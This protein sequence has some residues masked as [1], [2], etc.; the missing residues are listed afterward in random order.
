MPL[1]HFGMEQILRTKMENML[2][3][4]GL[5]IFGYGVILTGDSSVGKTDLGLELISRGHKFVADD[6]LNI[7]QHNQEL[8]FSNPLSQFIMHIRSIGFIDIEQTYGSAHTMH[9]SSL[10]VIIHLSNES[11]NN[12]DPLQQPK[13]EILIQGLPVMQYTLI[14]GQQRPLALLTELLVKYHEQNLNGFD[15][16][17]QFINTHTRLLQGVHACKLS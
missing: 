14:Q 3:G 15:S 12:L 2:H 1:K 5:N 4:V 17:R 7:C 13:Q 9:S 16:H 8:I 10:D 11:L 6:A